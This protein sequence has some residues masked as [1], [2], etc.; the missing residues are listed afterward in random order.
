MPQI[1]T[2][3]NFWFGEAD[4]NG[5]FKYRKEWF[6]K[7][8][9][10]DQQV[11][12]FQ[13]TYEQAAT[14]QFDSWMDSP[15]GCLALALLLDQVPRNLFRGQPKSFAT[16]AKALFVAQT[17]VSKGFDQQ[18]PPVQRFFL[19]MPLEHSENLE[20]QQQSVS[21]FHQFAENLD[22][23]DTYDYAIRHRDVID[24]FGRFPHR[25][26]ILG[27]SSTPQEV[28]FLKQPGSSF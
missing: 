14:G 23:R 20:H 12:Q 16:D 28:E 5:T 24:R 2:I 18:L 17:A 25:N 4:E 22:L 27:R 8:P 3:L 9:A 7:N 10:F 26:Q 1:E 15:Q 19:Y 11:Q 21:L 13:S 6:T